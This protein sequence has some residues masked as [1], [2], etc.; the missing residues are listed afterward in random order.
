[1]TG[2][3][4][5]EVNNLDR[6]TYIWIIKLITYEVNL[7]AN[8]WLIHNKTIRYI[9]CCQTIGDKKKVKKEEITTGWISQPHYYQYFRLDNSLL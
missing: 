2:S 3:D 6:K 9:I 4:L 1:M 5:K 7:V 8:H